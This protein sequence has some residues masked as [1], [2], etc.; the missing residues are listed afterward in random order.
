MTTFKKLL[1]VK[2]LVF[3]KKCFSFGRVVKFI[4]KQ[5]LNV[6][7]TK[8][9][10]LDTF[11]FHQPFLMNVSLLSSTALWKNISRFFTLE[12]HLNFLW[13][14]LGTVFQQDYRTA[15]FVEYKYQAFCLNYLFKTNKQ[16]TPPPKKH[17]KPTKTNKP[18]THKTAKTPQTTP[19]KKTP[20][21]RR[22]FVLVSFSMTGQREEKEKWVQTG[23]TSSQG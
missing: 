12:D 2:F 18:N 1:A 6:L 10:Y 22:A 15:V 5:Y 11:L 16:A 20:N 9:A 4:Y 3:I 13:S 7:W 8:I 21:P 17:Q 23:K 19:T 14:S